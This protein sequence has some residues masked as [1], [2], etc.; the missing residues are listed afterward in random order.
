MFNTSELLV[1]HTN[2]NIKSW[3]GMK[4]AHLK[5]KTSIPN[6]GSWFFK[7]P[8]IL[9]QR[10]GICFLFCFWSRR[11]ACATGGVFTY[12]LG[13]DVLA[14]ATRGKYFSEK[15][16]SLP[17]FELLQLYVHH[18][19]KLCVHENQLSLKILKMSNIFTVVLL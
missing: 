4:W 16:L 1:W 10:E 5:K 14:C 18:S 6:P 3:G 13:P 9:T 11:L 2:E 12:F 17:F 8:Q 15:N 7:G 19:L